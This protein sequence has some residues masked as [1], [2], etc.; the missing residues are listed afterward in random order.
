[1]LLMYSGCHFL[2]QYGPSLQLVD[3]ITFWLNLISYLGDL[4]ISFL[5]LIL[6]SRNELTIFG[7]AYLVFQLIASVDSR[8]RNCEVSDDVFSH[9][10]LTRLL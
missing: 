10:I 5:L 6:I 1:M 9:F 3:L 7:C 2:S 4:A 8:I